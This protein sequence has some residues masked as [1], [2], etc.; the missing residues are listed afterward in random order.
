MKVEVLLA[1][2]E[3]RQA[4]FGKAKVSFDSVDVPSMGREMLALV[5]PV[6][7]VVFPH[8]QGHRR[9]SRRPGGR[10]SRDRRG[11]G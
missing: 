9:L 4:P 8:R 6:V 7:F 5:D 11:P 1:P 2:V 10:H 3:L